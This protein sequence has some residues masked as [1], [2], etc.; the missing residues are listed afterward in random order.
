MSRNEYFIVET[1]ETQRQYKMYAKTEEEALELFNASKNKRFYLHRTLKKNVVCTVSEDVSFISAKAEPPAV[2]KSD[3]A[4]SRA[5]AESIKVRRG[6]QRAKMLRA[7]LNVEDATDDESGAISGL[8]LNPKCCYWKRASELRAAGLIEPTGEYRN[9]RAGE[10]QM[11]CRITELGR[12][13][14]GE[15]QTS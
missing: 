6:S 15:L 11:V 13:I 14:V 12:S 3:P 2:R 9:S 5:G 1:V 8:S 4:S 7:Y 10:K